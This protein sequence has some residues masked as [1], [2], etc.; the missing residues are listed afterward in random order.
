MLSWYKV[1]QEDIPEEGSAFAPVEFP[2]PG[3]AP[4]SFDNLLEILRS[5]RNGAL[6]EEH[7]DVFFEA[8]ENI[9]KSQEFSKYVIKSF[10][11]EVNGIIGPQHGQLFWDILWKAIETEDG[12]KDIINFLLE[13]PY[14]PEVHSELSKYILNNYNKWGMIPLSELLVSRWITRDNFPELFYPLREICWQGF[15]DSYYSKNL[16]SKF[17]EKGIYSKEDGDIFWEKIDG[18]YEYNQYGR[19]P[20]NEIEERQL[21][22]EDSAS[23]SFNLLMEKVITPEDGE[24]FLEIAR[25]CKES[26]RANSYI[27]PLLT[28]GNRGSFQSLEDTR[29][30]ENNPAITREFSGDPIFWEFVDFLKKS[31][32]EGM[33]RSSNTIARLLCRQQIVP[34]DG[35][36]FNELVEYALKTDSMSFLKELYFCPKSAIIFDQ[37]GVDIREKEGYEEGEEKEEDFVNVIKEETHPGLY[38]SGLYSLLSFDQ[39]SYKEG[40]SEFSEILDNTLDEGIFDRIKQDP[41][42]QKDIKQITDRLIHK[43]PADPEGTLIDVL[44]STGVKLDK[45]EKRKYLGNNLRDFIL[46]FYLNISTYR[47]GTYTD[48][49]LDPQVEAIYKLLKDTLGKALWPFLN[50]RVFE[51]HESVHDALYDLLPTDTNDFKNSPGFPDFLLRYINTPKEQLSRAVK[52]REEALNSGYEDSMEGIMDYISKKSYP[53]ATPEEMPFVK[54][55]SWYGHSV[56]TIEN[57][58]HELNIPDEKVI[59]PGSFKVENFT[60]KIL[61]KNDPLG[62]ILGDMTSC[63]QVLDGMAEE[64]VYDGYNNPNSG[65]LAVYNEKGT[66]VAQSWLRLGQSN[67]LYLDNIETITSYDKNKKLKSAFLNFSNIL[68]QDR[69]FS[70]VVSGTGYSDIVFDNK[71]NMDNMVG[72]GQPW[73]DLEFGRPQSGFYTDLE[74]S[75][76]KLAKSF[77]LSKFGKRIMWYNI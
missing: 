52:A 18:I 74:I 10:N 63:C 15:D 31:D 72:K 70:S 3:R 49:E 53:D 8:L 4:V 44:D 9:S 58:F 42:R 39:N 28:K 1:A 48:E 33:G 65:F 16:L 12:L 47:R 36:K 27:A 26:V 17:L 32:V 64:A 69:G 35:E 14:T 61:E 55:L 5:L 50:A 11:N 51:N 76:Y 25:K 37:F 66:L 57:F 59:E 20:K 71:V 56:D 7:G 68:K 38:W 62:V 21:L 23:F 30:Q 73:M 13:K 46:D 29:L 19:E 41:N 45:R 6:T 34:E 40:R 22:D 67:I 77:N 43:F 54:N 2:P 60:F 24:R 75:N